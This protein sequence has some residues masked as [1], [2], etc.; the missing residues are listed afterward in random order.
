MLFITSTNHTNKWKNVIKMNVVSI[1]IL[2]QL[3]INNKILC[4]EIPN[5]VKMFMELL[6]RHVDVLNY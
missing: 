3:Y 4:T 1:N 6:R 5:K 2:Y